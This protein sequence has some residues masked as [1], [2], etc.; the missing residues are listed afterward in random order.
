MKTKLTEDD[1]ERLLSSLEAMNRA[2]DYLNTG[3]V[4]HSKNTLL[5]YVGRIERILKINE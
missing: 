1:T 2:L 4:I 3:N 5:Y